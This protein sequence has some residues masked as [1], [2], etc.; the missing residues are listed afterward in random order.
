MADL[1]NPDALHHGLDQ[2]DGWSGDRDGI[3][4]T[5][6]FADFAESIA[7]VNRVARVAE[8]MNHH[9]DIHLSW[10]TVRLEV[11]TH[12]AGGVT[13]SDLDLATRIDTGESHGDGNLDNPRAGE[14]T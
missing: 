12:A 9:P 4:K 3:S 2:L 6:T 7:F 10:D 14:T 8:D 1:L 13:Q 5:Y 11:V